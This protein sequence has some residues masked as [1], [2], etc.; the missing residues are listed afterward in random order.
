MSEE[1]AERLR[2]VR[3]ASG[4]S[5]RELERT[6]HISSSSLSRYLSGQSIPPWSVVVALCQVAGVDPR[7]LRP[8]W[9]SGKRAPAKPRQPAQP[10][11][12][13]VSAG[14]NDLPYDVS[15]FT[16]RRDELA[17]LLEAART[18]R[19]VAIDGMA[20]VG[21]TAL[22]VRAA[23]RLAADY[24][25][26]QHYVDLHGFTPGREP[27]EP[28]EALRV[29][30]SALG[31]AS[32]GIPAT[33]PERA[34]LWRAELARRR[35]VIV[36]DNAADADQVRPLLPGAGASLAVVTSR[37]RMVELDAVR[38]I[39]LDVLPAADAAELFVSASG[40]A[41]PSGE[42]EAAAE[43]LRLC[44]YL[45]LAIRVAAARLRHRPSWTV[46]TLAERLRSGELDV[47][48]V[49]AMS[50]RQLDPAQRR[51]FRLLGLVPGE[52]VDAWAAAALADIPLGNARSLLEDLVDAHLLQESAAGRY[53]M[54]DLLRQVA[55]AET[56]PDRRPAIARLLDYY[57][58]TMLA[59]DAAMSHETAGAPIIVSHPPAA[60]P[61]FRGHDEALAWV[62][63]ETPDIVAAF[64]LA[65]ELGLDAATAGLA[66]AMA[67][68]F[69]RRGG[70]ER[71]SALLDAALPAADRLG[72]RRAAAWLTYRRGVTHQ[73]SGRAAEATTD[74]RAARELM[75]DVGDGEGEVMALQRLAERHMD[76]GC[77]QDAIDL[78]QQAA[79]L[80]PAGTSTQSHVVTHARIG[81]ALV[82]LGRFTPAHEA[83]TEAVRVARDID[84]LH[85]ETM[86]VRVLGAAAL[87]LGDASGALAHFRTALA[88]SRA[89]GH[90]IA[91]ALSL[92]D[93][94]IAAR[95]LGRIVEAL[96]HHAEA[97]NIINETGERLRA[98]PILIPYGETCLAAG[99]RGAA[100][101]HLRQAFELARTLGLRHLEAEAGRALAT[102][103]PAAVPPGTHTGQPAIT[104]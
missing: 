1:L 62:D 95:A 32:A 43:V 55:V 92:T 101:R 99:D 98:A 93:L 14:R 41:R 38:P 69:G 76:D 52:G 65:V 67:V 75:A 61:A 68:Y 73:F 84:D 42:P 13:V 63:A 17:A 81:H 18:H 71:W 3:E 27:V 11:A 15:G 104:T 36:L 89:T 91:E 40:G 57:L 64:E 53:R 25:D 19:M 23:H 9:E 66:Q 39:S 103:D 59:A 10:S 87:G 30:L 7:P 94:A 46:A 44:G 100:E 29:L 97:L 16:G 77:F 8:V 33:G 26:G 86:G 37:R 48:N 35:A 2:Q 34:A 78:L 56:S 90:R 96:D 79:D 28:D 102:L 82:Q 80:L 31:V 12:P 70:M 54:H 24:P 88:Q 5:L 47:S 6:I 58:S 49:L 22:A 60:L 51:M 50:L 72:D 83:A 21:K 20:G 45:P 74:Y 4:R 85:L